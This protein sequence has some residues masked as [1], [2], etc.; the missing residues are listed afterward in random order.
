MSTEPSQS[1]RVLRLRQVI[2]RVGL[3]RSTIYDRINPKSSR[4]D[5]SFPKPIKIGA[6]AIGW[7]ESSISEWIESRIE[8]GRS[9]V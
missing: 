9:L 2:Q 4:Y 1:L 6:S 5:E 8:Q 7:I 3:S